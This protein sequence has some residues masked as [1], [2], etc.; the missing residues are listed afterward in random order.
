MREEARIFTEELRH[1]RDMINEEVRSTEKNQSGC[2]RLLQQLQELRIMAVD[3][4]QRIEGI[5]ES[6]DSQNFYNTSDELERC[7]ESEIRIAPARRQQI[8]SGIPVDTEILRLDGPPDS[9]STLVGAA[10]KEVL[11]V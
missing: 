5:L 8:L 1:F 4:V 2:R 9:N 6:K 10:P 3:E 11:V 7:L